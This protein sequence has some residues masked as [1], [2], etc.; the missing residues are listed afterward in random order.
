MRLTTYLLFDVDLVLGLR[1]CLTCRYEAELGDAT[2]ELNKRGA[3]VKQLRDKLA[4]VK[5]QFRNADSTHD[6]VRELLQVRL[7]L[8][9][10]GERNS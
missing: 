2:D 5:A 3:E 10:R 9:E 6:D 4:V 1:A 7:G 8:Q